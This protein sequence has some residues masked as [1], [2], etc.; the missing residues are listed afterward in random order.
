MNDNTW[1][2]TQFLPLALVGLMALTRFDHFGSA[3]SLPDA[4]LAVFFLA[5][6][7]FS[8]LWFFGI[9]ILEAGLI[10]YVAIT[11][12][13]VS[14]FCISPAYLFLLPAYAA[15]WFGGRYAKNLAVLDFASSIKMLGLAALSTTAAFIISNGSFYLLSG[16]FGELSLNQYLTQFGHYFL[17]YAAS[18]LMY[19]ALGLGIAKLWRMAQVG[20][21]AEL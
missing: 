14:D 10:D 12:L 17:P 5:G 16:R 15:L 21:V 9:L 3:I 18:A 2:K 4:S 1:H 8:P 20:A 7:G 13:N 19:I 11:A 6:F